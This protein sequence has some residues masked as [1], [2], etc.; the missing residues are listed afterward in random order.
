MKLF[1]NIFLSTFLN[2]VFADNFVIE[3]N[4]P[5]DFVNL[6]QF[7]PQ[8]QFDIRYYG[9]H[10][11]VGRRINGYESPVCLITKSAAMA[12][13]KVESKLLGMNLTLKAYDCYRPQRAVDDFANWATQIDNVK[14]KKE[15]YPSVDKVNLFKENYIAYRSGHS[16]GST[17]DLTIVPIQSAVPKYN[18]DTPLISCIAP[19]QKRFP[20]NSLD[21]GTG[22]DC[23]SPVSHPLYQNLSAQILANRL[24]LNTL[25]NEAGFKGIDSEWWH[26]T[27]ANEAYPH[28]IFDFIVK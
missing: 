25:M 9:S 3:K 14:M 28:T 22:F 12:L 15:F 4:R 10:N 23:F 8:M 2:F 5:S 21:F 6:Q 20:D 26:F 13:K 1:I 17:I 18:K 19:K 11:F 27:F 24:L 7:I 16:R